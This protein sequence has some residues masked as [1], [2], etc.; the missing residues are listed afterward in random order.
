MFGNL[1]NSTD[2]AKEA[3][4]YSYTKHINGFSAMLEDEEAMEI[5]SK[6]SW[7]IFIIC[8]MLY[9]PLVSDLC[10]VGSTRPF[11]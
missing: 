6:Q 4:F 8:I 5:S 3:I 11:I 7:I 1:N 10:R 2:K 9:L